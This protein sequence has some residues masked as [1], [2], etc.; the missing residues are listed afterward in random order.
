MKEKDKLSEKNDYISIMRE[1]YDGIESKNMFIKFNKNKN[2]YLNKGVF[3][4]MNAFK[5]RVFMSSQMLLVCRLL[6]NN[7]IST[8]LSLIDVLV[9]RLSR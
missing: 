5:D 2:K 3:I 8:K 7:K 1:I 9:M 4:F 6:K